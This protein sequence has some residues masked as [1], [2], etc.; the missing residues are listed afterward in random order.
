MQRSLLVLTWASVP[1][2]SNISVQLIGQNQLDLICNQLDC[3]SVFCSECYWNPVVFSRGQ[4]L[5]FILTSYNPA[6]TSDS[7]ECSLHRVRFLLT[8]PISS[9]SPVRLL[10]ERLMN[11][12]SSYGDNNIHSPVCFCYAGIT[13]IAPSFCYGGLA[14]AYIGSQFI[15]FSVL[16]SFACFIS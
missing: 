5:D 9:F 1:L 11:S 2:E 7:S 8:L 12:S 15:T 6:I 3:R 10:M 13:V 4:Q 14:R 16:S